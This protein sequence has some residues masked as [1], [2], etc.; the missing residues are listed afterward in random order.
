[1]QTSHASLYFCP[2]D[3]VNALPQRSSDE[4]TSE[5]PNQTCG[6]KKLV[7]LIPRHVVVKTPR[8]EISPVS[9]LMAHVLLL[10]VILLLRLEKAF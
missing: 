2:A 3:T 6:M 1:M 4:D 7:Q 8:E 5:E 10:G 9:I